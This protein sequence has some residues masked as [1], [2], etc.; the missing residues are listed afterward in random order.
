M[1]ANTAEVASDSECENEQE[2]KTEADIDERHQ[3]EHQEQ[4]ERRLQPG[5]P[6]NAPLLNAI[7]ATTRTAS[8]TRLPSFA[9]I[10]TVREPKP[11]LELEMETPS[12]SHSSP[13]PLASLAAK[14]TAKLL[15]QHQLQAQTDPAR[16]NANYSFDSESLR[17][18]LRFSSQILAPAH[19]T[20]A[21]PFVIMHALLLVHRIL[22]QQQQK[23]QQEPTYESNSAFATQISPSSQ[24]TPSTASASN[25]APPLP[26]SLSSPTNLLLAGIILADNYLNDH[27]VHASV[28]SNFQ[29]STTHSIRSIKHDAL[30]CLGYNVGVNEREFGQWCT[31]VRKWS[32]NI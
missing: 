25:S 14:V 28:F 20:P 11:E 26:S 32:S 31:V 2:H 17:N 9:I 22:G 3:Q 12:D 19:V 13:S 23:Q 15:A 7:S 4:Q 16:T 29:P 21:S 10:I 5:Q 24:E 1:T 8:V 27:P 18:L 6:P 30:L